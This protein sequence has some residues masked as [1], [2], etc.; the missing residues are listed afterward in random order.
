[1]DASNRAGVSQTTTAGDREQAFLAFVRSH[2]A[3]DGG[4]PVAMP[5]YRSHIS[6]WLLWCHHQKI[7]V[8]QATI[9]DVRQYRRL[10]A[11]EGIDPRVVSHKLL[12]L[13]RFY[14]HA[15]KSGLAVENPALGIFPFHSC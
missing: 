6:A 11:V 1:M 13:R 3:D 15:V 10:L 7:Q 9:A 4:S 14:H 5:G 8:S 2:L 12:V